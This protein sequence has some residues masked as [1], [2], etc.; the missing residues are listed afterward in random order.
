M[1]MTRSDW[2]SPS[3][4][5][6]PAWEHLPPYRAL[7]AAD[8]KTRGFSPHRDSAHGAAGVGRSP[9]EGTTQL[10]LVPKTNTCLVP[11]AGRSPVQHPSA[12][13]E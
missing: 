8:P 7:R 11:D 13:I 9:G 1:A 12:G 2:L 4:S 10:G 5:P 6:A 3:L